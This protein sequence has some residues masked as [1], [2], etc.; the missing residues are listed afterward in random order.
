VGVRC[1]RLS[2]SYPT[3]NGTVP[4][5]RDVTLDLREG[6]FVCLVGPSGCGK[7][8]LLKVLAGLIPPDSGRLEIALD[9][10]HGD[11]HRALAFQEHSVFPWMTVLDNVAFGLEFRGVARRERERRALA[12]IEQVGLGD[13]ARSYPHQLSVGMR[14][15]VNLARAFVSEPDVLL[16]DEPFGALDALTKLVLQEELLRIWS[17]RS[18][19]VVYVTHDLEEAV[20]LGDRVVVMS[21]RPGTILADLVVPL[22]RPRDRATRGLAEVAQIKERLWELLEGEVRGSLA[23][24]RSA[25]S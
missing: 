16:M 7:S 5:L 12:F 3:R 22:S 1:D 11:A 20:L 10:A 23:G 4:A 24:S 14:Q 6:E 9:G 25:A 18:R 19:L 21:G 15:R 13:F 17:E 2:L 8:T